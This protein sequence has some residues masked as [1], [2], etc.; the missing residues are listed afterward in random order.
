VTQDLSNTPEEI[1]RLAVRFTSADPP[2]ADF[3]AAVQAFQTAASGGV[4]I[5]LML[6]GHSSP[7]YRPL[8]EAPRRRKWLYYPYFPFIPEAQDDFFRFLDPFDP[9]DVGALVGLN[10]WLRGSLLADPPAYEAAFGDIRVGD[11]GRDSPVFIILTIPIVVKLGGAITG[12]AAV[13]RLIEKY[14]DIKKTRAETRRAEGEEEKARAEAEKARAEAEKARAETEKIRTETR[15][16]LGDANFHSEMAEH[17]R[18]SN[19]G[20]SED[21]VDRAA[22][23]GAKAAEVAIAEL[24]TNPS[25]F[26]VEADAGAAA[27][28]ARV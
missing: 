3:T 28:T 2:G 18:R 4:W 23:A 22:A 27:T 9:A 19:P 24:E 7:F 8:T 12:T 17:L 25:V 13:V 1:G 11:V 26:D 15:Q 6:A 21:S 16:I 20:A 10:A 14:F 5:D